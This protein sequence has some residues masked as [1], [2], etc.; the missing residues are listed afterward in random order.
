MIER[1]PVGAYLI[2]SNVTAIWRPLRR[3]APGS[4]AIG[5]AG[6]GLGAEQLAAWRRKV[7]AG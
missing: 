7:D 3:A 5:F 1:A 6:C 4:G 2:G